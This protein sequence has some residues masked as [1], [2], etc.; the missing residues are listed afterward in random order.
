MSRIEYGDVPTLTISCFYLEGEADEED[1][2]RGARFI[3]H[4][5]KVRDSLDGCDGG[6][7]YRKQ[8]DQIHNTLADEFAALMTH[9]SHCCGFIFFPVHFLYTPSETQ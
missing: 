2:A 4:Q 5:D 3:R 8:L 6:E 7:M 9:T 1:A